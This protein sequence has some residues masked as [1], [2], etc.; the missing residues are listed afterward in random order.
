MNKGFANN[1][2]AHEVVD[3]GLKPTAYLAVVF[4]HGHVLLEFAA[5]A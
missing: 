2:V 1:V 5:Q 3:P 4:A